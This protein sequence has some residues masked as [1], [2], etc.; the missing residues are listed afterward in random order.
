MTDLKT[1]QDLELLTYHSGCFSSAKPG[2]R[3]IQEGEPIICGVPLDI[4]SSYRPG[5]RFGPDAIR[6][7]SACL[8][9][10]SIRN[11]T[12]IEHVGYS[13]IGNLHFD[14]SEPARVHEFL[15][16]AS[17]VIYESDHFP[18]FL[19]G[20]H[21]ITL[22]L[23]PD[24]D[25]LGIVILDAHLDL[26]DSYLSQKLSHACVTRRISEIVGIENVL[27]LG[28]RGISS[29]EMQFVDETNFNHITSLELIKSFSRDSSVFDD[30]RKFIDEH[31]GIYLSVDMDVFDPAFGMGV[32]NP[33]PEGIT[34]TIAMDIINIIKRDSL[35]GCDVVEVCPGNDAG[36]SALLAARL[37]VECLN[38]K[39]GS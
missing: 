22:S 13:D 36:Q 19:G 39:V 12:S 21:S 7:Y 4:T 17:F 34:P 30:I 29:E 31:D 16:S 10:G 25:N 2:F 20:E 9:L 28:T 32:G 1:I 27:V 6:N 35:V 23:I 11:G 18:V 37:V 14:S 3:W 5:T 15:S 26:R 38:K 33:E 8:E 24:H